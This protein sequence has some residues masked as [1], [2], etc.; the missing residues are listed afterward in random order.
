MHRNPVN[1]LPSALVSFERKRLSCA[2][3]TRKIV[4]SFGNTSK[5]AATGN[6]AISL[7]QTP[8]HVTKLH[9]EL[10]EFLRT[11]ADDFFSA[12]EAGHLLVSKAMLL[13]VDTQCTMTR[14]LPQNWQALEAD[15]WRVL[16]Y[17]GYLGAAVQGTVFKQFT[18]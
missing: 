12:T 8:C 11:I 15:P 16:P 18:L 6:T 7:T 17:M 1:S 14:N 5:R 10:S 13:T 3:T 9:L 4:D 2:M